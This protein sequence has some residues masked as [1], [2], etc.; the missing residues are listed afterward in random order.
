[1]K[2]RL[3]VHCKLIQD[4]ASKY[5]EGDRCM[6][7]V[8]NLQDLGDLRRERT[9]AKSALHLYFLGQHTLE[10]QL[11][12]INLDRHACGYSCV[13]GGVCGWNKVVLDLNFVNTW[14]PLATTKGRWFAATVKASLEMLEKE[15]SE[16]C[17]E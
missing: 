2:L 14:G 17:N 13:R 3:A 7:G 11:Y 4:M 10:A 6:V 16:C 12:R 9:C 15:T 5:L 8:S 1:M